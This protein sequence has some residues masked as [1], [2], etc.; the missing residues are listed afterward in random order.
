[1]LSL[2][3]RKDSQNALVEELVA[4]AATLAEGGAGAAAPD[5]E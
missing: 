4:F 3:W 2:A 5:G 1:M